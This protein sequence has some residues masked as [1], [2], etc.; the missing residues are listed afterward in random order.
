MNMNIFLSSIL[1][2]VNTLINPVEGQL[3]KHNNSAYSHGEVLTYRLHYGFVDAGEAVLE[4]KADE[5]KFGDRSAFHI[6]GTG[7][8]KGAFDWFFKVR[9]RY[10][11]YIDKDALVPWVFIRRVDEGGYKI[12]QNYVFNHY[13]K[14][15]NCDGKNFAIPDNVQDMLSSFYYARCM[16]FSS[17]KEGDVFEITGFVDNE[18]YPLKIKYIG[19][20]IITTDLG[21]FRCLKFRPV[22]QKGRVFKQEEDLNVWIT[23]DKNHVPIRAQ[24][25]ILVGS[26]KMDLKSHKGLANPLAVVK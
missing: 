4:V 11:T 2:S 22:V 19:K 24:A 20:E 23:D 18:I 10:E 15:V 5:K 3:R 6:V 7:T 9:D 12:N 14:N 25:N 16:D 21:K 17:A 1:L 13:K 26:I 8:S